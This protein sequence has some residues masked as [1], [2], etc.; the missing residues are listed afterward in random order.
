MNPPLNVTVI[1][2]SDG[3]ARLEDFM[4]RTEA[5]SIDCE[6]PVTEGFINQKLRTIQIGDRN[7]Q[8]VIDLLGF[9]G[10]PEAL[11]A[12]QGNYGESAELLLGPVIRTLR[13]YL[14]NYSITKVGVNLESDYKALR[15]CLGIRMKGMYDCHL[16]EK[17]LL[18]GLVHF[19]Q[20]G[21]W[22]FEDLVRKYIGMELQD[23][24]TGKT[25]DLSTPL[26]ETQITYVALDVRLPMAVRNGQL[27]EVR[28][29]GLE[30]A[31][32]ID[33]DAIS[34]FSEMYLSGIG[35][36][37]DAWQKLID[38]NTAK[39]RAIIEKLDTLF[40][41]VV[42]TKYVSP[43][44]FE[45]LSQLEAEWRDCPQKTEEEKE[46]R[47]QLRMSYMTLRKDVNGRKKVSDECEGN[48]AINYRS[49]KQ[50]LDALRKMGFG[51]R[52]L[53]DT[54]DKSLEKLSK[55]RDL[56]VEQAFEKDGGALNYPVIDLIRLYRTVGKLIDT[57]G[58]AWITPKSQGGHINDSTGRI[59]SYVNLLGAATGRTSASNP[60]CQNI[61]KDAA[62]RHC[63][64][65]R[66]GYKT[67]TIDYNGAELRILAYMSQD[68]VWL[69]AF[70]NGW[71]VHSVGAE[72]LYGDRWKNAA[73]SGCAYCA[74]RHKCNCKEHKVLRNHIKSVGT[75]S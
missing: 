22:A 48:A 65:A 26:T 23:T 27:R 63:F 55:N 1:S 19:M 58:A 16:A 13:P 33:C 20:K 18:A 71:D 35:I 40:I 9:A 28:A 75:I 45:R 32:R 14:E 62:Y 12:S 8:Y 17:N 10:T 52:Q 6:W 69:E 66:P 56:T 36:D 2:D 25:F 42:G 43:E 73:E 49:N 31:V 41:P 37:K 21:K 60:N 59:H 54:N 38:A 3:L 47:R 7:E 70:G 29:A 15:W 67:I 11:S 24:E 74:N 39:K 44:D 34:P 30:A 68:P 53:K 46:R 64:T 57:Y 72:M 5:F 51:A 4:K 50:L 61:P